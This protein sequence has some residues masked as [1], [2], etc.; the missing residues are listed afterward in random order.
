MR[1]F[2]ILVS[3]PYLQRALAEYRP[4]LEARGF[5]LV[6]PA[7]RE[8]LSE[9]ELLPLVAGVD[10]MIAGD[11]QVTERVLER[12]DRLK[13]VVKWGTGIDSIDRD[14][15]ARRG[16][17]VRNTPG[18][19]TEPVADTVI[20]YLLC[21]VRSLPFLDRSV[22]TGRWEKLPGRALGECTLGIIGVG[23]IGS[24]VARRAAAFGATILGTD[25]VPVPAALRRSTGLRPV[26]LDELLGAA[27]LISLNCDL[28]PTSHHLVNEETLGLVKPGAVLVNTARGPIVDEGALVRALQ[29]GRISGAALDVFEDEPLPSD[30]P[31]R[32]MDNV[33]LAPHS[34]NSSPRAWRRVHRSS[35]D[36]LV[37]V[38]GA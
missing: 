4:E 14:A 34:S 3:A 27:D 5:E 30:S 12:A 20:G 25:P 35:I 26:P 6:L 31:L 23:N 11:D 29:D 22:R 1:G 7:V 10:G 33:L 8:R 36:Q 38:L 24:A 32:R 13:V 28:N 9:D 17:A 21:F 15:C 19:F 2:R 16:V 18:A 37:E